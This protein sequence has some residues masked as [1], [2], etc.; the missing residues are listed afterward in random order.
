MHLSNDS[1]LVGLSGGHVVELYRPDTR[2]TETVAQFLCVQGRS[3]RSAV[4]CP[5]EQGRKARTV[6]TI[7]VATDSALSLHE[8]AT[9]LALS[10]SCFHFSAMTFDV[11]RRLVCWPSQLVKISRLNHVHFSEAYPWIRSRVRITCY[12]VST[13]DD[14]QPVH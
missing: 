11:L 1:T 6:A 12:H 3:S 2:Q 4:V 13:F 5:L 9:H 10:K 8:D 14:S 7:K